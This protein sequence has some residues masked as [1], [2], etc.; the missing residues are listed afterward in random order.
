M[1]YILVYILFIVIVSNLIY[2]INQLI[3][4]YTC[5]VIIYCFV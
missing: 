5:N 1:L 3:D 4:R 2:L